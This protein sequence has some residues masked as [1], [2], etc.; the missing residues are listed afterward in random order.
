MKNQLIGKVPDAGKIKDRRRRGHQMMRWMDG[1]N[2]AMG[3]TLGKLQEMV[4]SRKAWCAAV[5][6]VTKS[7]T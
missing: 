7:Q 1:I 5:L 3:M 6:G 4:K 2:D